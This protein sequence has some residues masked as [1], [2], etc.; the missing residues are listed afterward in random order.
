MLF[1]YSSVCIGLVVGSILAVSTNSS[2]AAAFSFGNNG[3]KFDTDTEA[4][5]NFVSSQGNYQS[6]F[7]VYDEDANFTPLFVENK[8]FD[9]RNPDFLGTCG[10]ATSAVSNCTNSFT[11][12][13]NVE[14]SF[15]LTSLEDG[16]AKPTVY[17]TTTLNV[18]PTGFDE[19]AKF[20]SNNPFTNLVLI[21][22]EDRLVSEG[23]YIDFNDFKVN[24]QAKN[25]SA[26]IPEPAMLAGLALVGGGIVATRRRK[27]KRSY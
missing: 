14:Y 24:V 1:K 13:K 7:G 10:E 26:R 25:G 2:P 9:L 11:F 3:I 23:E 20:S 27:A 5:F 19:Q 15:A 12:K 17:S 4:D 6:T 21:S 16:V 22:F 8:P 18:R